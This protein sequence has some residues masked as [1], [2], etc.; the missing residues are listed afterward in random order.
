MRNRSRY[1]EWRKRS[2]ACK[3]AAHW[4]CQ[5][6]GI[7]HGKLRLTWS[8]RMWPAWLQAAH[9]NHDP[10][11][12]ESELVAVCAWCHWRYYRKP[13]TRPCWMIERAKHR[14]LL[15]SKGYF[16]EALPPG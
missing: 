2:K 14:H 12:R 9:P 1:P 11:N 10:E 6:C 7:E 13:G 15:E 16:V 8:G 3:E 5:K 4:H